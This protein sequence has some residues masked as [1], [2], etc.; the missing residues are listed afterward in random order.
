MRKTDKGKVEDRWMTDTETKSRGRVWRDTDKE[1]RKREM[2]WRDT[3]KE[4][5]KRKGWYGGIQTKSRG[6]SRMKKLFS[7]ILIKIFNT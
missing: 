7:F 2:V 3:D 1:Q 6:S 4:Q 5:R